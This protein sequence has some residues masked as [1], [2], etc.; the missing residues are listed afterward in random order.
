MMVATTGKRHE[1]CRQNNGSYY[2]FHNVL[3]FP[4]GEARKRGISELSEL[5]S[6]SSSLGVVSARLSRMGP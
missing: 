2:V 4:D 3:A 1:R 6:S 5:G